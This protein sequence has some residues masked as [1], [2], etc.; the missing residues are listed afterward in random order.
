MIALFIRQDVEQI[1]LLEAD[2]VRI[3]TNLSIRDKKKYELRHIELLLEEERQA[4]EEISRKC[5]CRLHIHQMAFDESD[6]QKC[7]KIL[8]EEVQTV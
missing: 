2:P 6:L 5:S 1:L 4:A 3:L 8:N 7:C